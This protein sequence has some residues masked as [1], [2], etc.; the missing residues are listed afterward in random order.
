MID[1]AA[2]RESEEIG[3][4]KIRLHGLTQHQSL[5]LAV[6]G[7]QADPGRDGVPRRFDRQR[8]AIQLNH[9][10]LPLV[11]AE[12]QSRGLGPARSN[13]PRQTHDLAPHD[14]ERHIPDTR[15]ARQA[16]HDEPLVANLASLLGELILQFPPHHQF[17][18]G[19]PAQFPDGPCSHAHAVSQDRHPIRDSKDLIQSMADVDPPDVLRLEF[20]NN[21]KQVIHFL[22]GQRRAGFVHHNDPCVEGQCLG[23]LDDLLLRHGQVPTE[24]GRIDRHL[25]PRKE[26]RGNL[27]LLPLRNKTSA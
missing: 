22:Q 11:R 8:F 16:A 23:D 13:Q 6:L 7:E 19:F 18:H 9:A 20:P 14:G 25:Q 4:A 5:C 21:R 2:P 3:Q 26:L 1:K 17:D 15:G 12:H 24:R 10:R 27:M